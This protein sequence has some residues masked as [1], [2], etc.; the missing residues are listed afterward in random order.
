MDI[1]DESGHKLSEFTLL[2]WSEILGVGDDHVM[3][4]NHLGCIG[5]LFINGSPLA[6]GLVIL[7]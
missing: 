3:A 4:L 7:V 2:F 6:E 5:V 1:L